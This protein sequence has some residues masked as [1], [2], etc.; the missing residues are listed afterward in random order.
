MRQRQPGTAGAH[1]LWAARGGQHIDQH[2]SAVGD[3]LPHGR[4]V[5]DRGTRY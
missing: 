3:D 1:R 4:E 5:Q 2:R